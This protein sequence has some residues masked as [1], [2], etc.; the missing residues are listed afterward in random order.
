MIMNSNIQNVPFEYGI[1]RPEKR[2]VH[3]P[4]RCKWEKVLIKLKE[5]AKN[6]KTPEEEPCFRIATKA[7]PTVIATANRLGIKVETNQIDPYHCRV[8]PVK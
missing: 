1:N 2:R 7:R 5:E 3:K 4:S 8:Y 6:A